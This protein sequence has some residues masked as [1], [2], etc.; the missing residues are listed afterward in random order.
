MS[1]FSHSLIVG[2]TGSGKTHFAKRFASGLLSAKQQVIVFTTADASEWDSRCHIA[3]EIDDLEVMLNRKDL[4]GAFVF[5]DESLDFF[6]DINSKKH[7]ICDRLHRKGRHRGFKTFYMSQDYIAIPKQ[8]R[9]NVRELYLFDL[10]ADD[11]V[12]RQVE[13]EF[14]GVDTSKYS[15][16]LGALIMDLNDYAFLHIKNG[17]IVTRTKI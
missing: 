11:I 7:K 15:R 13:R 9:R 8:I 3:S 16:K 6:D 5:I 12:A 4:A 14:S 10:G 2:C 17:G 1:D